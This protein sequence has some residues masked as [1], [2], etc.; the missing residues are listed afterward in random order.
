M[1]ITPSH[2]FPAVHSDGTIATFFQ[3]RDANMRN[4][5]NMLVNSGYSKE[6][7][8]SIQ[9]SV[10]LEQKLDFITKDLITGPWLVM[11]M[12]CNTFG[13]NR[14]FIIPVV[15]LLLAGVQWKTD[16]FQNIFRFR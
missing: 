15:I 16:F 9:S 10:K 1:V 7:R 14:A 11:I 4:P 13:S 2:V 5:Y 3:E 12:T 8:S 6:W